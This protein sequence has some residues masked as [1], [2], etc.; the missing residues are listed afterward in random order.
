MQSKSEEIKTAE[1]L[2]RDEFNRQ[3]NI[4]R[5]RFR[6]E[7]QERKDSKTNKVVKRLALII[8]VLISQFLVSYITFLW[9]IVGLI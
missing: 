9:I 7:L 5:E 4:E 2:S 6:K 8:L 3:Q 1:W